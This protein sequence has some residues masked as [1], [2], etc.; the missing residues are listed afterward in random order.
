MHAARLGFDAVAMTEHAQSSYDMQPN[1][2]LAA[3][4][5][6]YETEKEGIEVAIYTVGRSL[7]KSREPL[8]IAEEQAWLDTLSGGRLICGCPVGLAYDANIN[9]GVAPI[10]TRARYDE[11][12]EFILRAW[13]ERDSFPFNGKFS[14]HAKVNIWPR[15][16]QNPH[17]P[18]NITGTGNPATTR[19]AL[20]RDLGFNLVVLG[21][22]PGGA[23]RIF[24][25]LWAMADKMGL[26]DNPYRAAY[27]QFICVAET[28]ADAERLYARHIEYCMGFGIGYIPFHRLALPGGISPAGLRALL[29]GGAPAGGKEHA[30]RYRDLVDSGAVIAGSAAT[31]RERLATQARTM[32]FGN[33]LAFLQI[34]S[35]PS[36]LTRYNIDLFAAQ[37]LPHLRP[38]WSDF[39]SKNRW[40]PT[41]LGGQPVSSKQAD[42]TGARLS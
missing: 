15:P 13:T 38:L 5:L 29:S 40:W 14:Q 21:G 25:D 24:G 37:V 18:V 23:E 28:D 4:V 1:P 17:P 30:P 3:A 11:N 9:A 12:F 10:E 41:R 20:E 19:F 32:R 34:G 36:D 22:A 35:M 33:L 31:V 39:N 8:R 16:F 27:A 6:A 42:K 2:D 26:D 7:G